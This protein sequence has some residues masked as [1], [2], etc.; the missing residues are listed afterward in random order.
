M[1]ELQGA[2][3][4]YD[5]SDIFNMDETGLF[6]RYMPNWSYVPNGAQ[7]TV[8]GFI[9]L[10]SKQRLTLVL[11]WDATGKQNVSPAII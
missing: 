8:R 3:N 9:A 1:L 5:L 4:E 6:Y 11:C 10:K 7:R 2:I